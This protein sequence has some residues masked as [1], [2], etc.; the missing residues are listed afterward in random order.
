MNNFVMS[1]YSGN[2]YRKQQQ[3]KSDLRELLMTVGF[4]SAASMAG[5]LLATGIVYLIV[6]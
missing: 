4:I 6:S 2:F 5:G 1:L 3:T